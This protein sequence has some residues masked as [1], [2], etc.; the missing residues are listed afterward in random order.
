MDR[1]DAAVGQLR[2]HPAP[3]AMPL[4]EYGDSVMEL[5]VCGLEFKTL[6]PYRA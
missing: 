4:A 2:C 6:D 3:A 1:G 5:A